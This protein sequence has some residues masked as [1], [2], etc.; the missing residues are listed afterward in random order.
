M[1]S[2]RLRAVHRINST[3]RQDPAENLDAVSFLKYK[4]QEKSGN[5][6]MDRR[7]TEIIFLFFIDLSGYLKRANKGSLLQNDFKSTLLGIDKFVGTSISVAVSK[8]T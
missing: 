2:Y 8:T 7:C 5:L 4:S 3:L 1:D 6:C